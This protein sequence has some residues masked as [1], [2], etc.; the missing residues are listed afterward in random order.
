MKYKN[1]FKCIL[2][3]LNTYLFSQQSYKRALLYNNLPEHLENKLHH[4]LKN[5]LT[6]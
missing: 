1:F 3:H 2:Y 5:Q 6:L 4:Q